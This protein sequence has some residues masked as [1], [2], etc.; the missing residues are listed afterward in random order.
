MNFSEMKEF[1][2]SI[3]TDANY[4]DVPITPGPQL[5]DLPDEY[6]L[7]TPYGGTGLNTDGVF[8]SRA[9]QVRVVGPQNDYIKGEGMADAIDLAFIS[10]MSAHVSGQWVTSIER[11][12]GAPTPLMVDDADRTHFTCNY[13]V[14]AESALAN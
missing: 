8:D 7:L 9:W 3:L 11:V 6:V 5:P 4:L 10:H 2:S 1:V 12:G 14:D 13:N